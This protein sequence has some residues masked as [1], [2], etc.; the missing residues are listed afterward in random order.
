MKEKI[1]KLFK[2]DLDLN[3]CNTT[4]CKIG[5]CHLFVTIHITTTHVILKVILL[6]VIFR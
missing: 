4:D 5:T 1:C 6:P 2:Q 3:P